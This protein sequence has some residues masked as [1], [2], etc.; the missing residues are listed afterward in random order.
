MRVFLDTN[1]LIS[2]FATRGLCADLFRSVIAEHDLV[3]GEIVLEEF[4]RVLRTRFKMPRDRIDQAE[5]LLRSYEVIARPTAKDPVLLRD[6][7]DRWVL[8]KARAEISM[9]LSRVTRTF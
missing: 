4:R 6:S 8:A 1:A 9:C 5:E 7:D 3:V 2:A